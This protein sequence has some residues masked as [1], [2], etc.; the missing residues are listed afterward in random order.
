MDRLREFD[1]AK[2]VFAP[3]TV[4]LRGDFCALIAKPSCQLVSRDD[5]GARALRYRQRISDMIAVPMRQH[6]KIRLQIICFR[7]RFRVPRKERIDKDLRLFTLE[8]NGRVSE[9]GR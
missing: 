3:A 1:G 2:W 5:R 4:I 8:I 6:D 7:R 9:K